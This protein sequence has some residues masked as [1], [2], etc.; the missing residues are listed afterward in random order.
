MDAWWP[1]LLTAEFKSRLG[2]AVFNDLEGMLGFGSVYTSQ[3][4]NEP[5]MA[6]GWYGYVSKDLLDLIATHDR[7]REPP[8]AYA[9][10]YCGSGSFNRC[11]ATL[12]SSLRAALSVTPK[13]MYGYGACA[14]N[15]QPSCFDSNE[16]TDVSAIS[17]PPFPF[18][19]RPTFQQVVELTRTLPR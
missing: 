13:Q 2:P 5:D 15:P 18:Q 6:Q 4:P 17:L 9:K 3:A 14:S 8:G 1:L 12:R 10:I 19:N 16:W 11:R 7:R